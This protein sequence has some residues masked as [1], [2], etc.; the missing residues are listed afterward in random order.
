MKKSTK[1]FAVVFFWVLI[2]NVFF[3]LRSL[4]KILFILFQ[5]AGAALIAVGVLVKL[6]VTDAIS[7]GDNNIHLAPIFT[8]I[9]GAVIFVIAFFG[10]CGAIRES[11]CM[12]TTVSNPLLIWL[13][14]LHYYYFFIVR[15]YSVNI[16]HFT[17]CYW[18]LCIH[19]NKR[20]TWFTK[21]SGNWLR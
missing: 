11:T 14:N 3:K 12:L 15:N 21:R 8:I 6:N 4:I 17:S 10:C 9:V 16:L 1:Q 5:L 18:C 7:E 2:Y 19:R 13:I 20:W